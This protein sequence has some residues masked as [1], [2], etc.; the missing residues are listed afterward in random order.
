MLRVPSYAVGLVGVLLLATSCSDCHYQFGLK[1]KDYPQYFGP[2][3]LANRRHNEE[4]SWATQLPLGSATIVVEHGV[5]AS[6][7]DLE[8]VRLP[9]GNYLFTGIDFGSSDVSSI[10]VSHVVGG[11][12]LEVAGTFLFRR[13]KPFSEQKALEW[14]GAWDASEG[15]Y[16]TPLTGDSINVP[17]PDGLVRL[18]KIESNPLLPN[19]YLFR[20]PLQETISL[21]VGRDPNA[22]VYD[23]DLEAQWGC[24]STFW[25]RLINIT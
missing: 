12:P 6:A 25:S 15:W 23:F 22:Q 16:V 2:S 13:Y 10:R 5:L 21:T 4:Y 3:L 9:P 18:Y 1:E 8:R 20:E 7:A 17:Y 19:G 24:S 11:K 14:P